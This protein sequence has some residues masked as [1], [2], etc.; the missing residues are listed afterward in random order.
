MTNYCSF[1]QEL[2][3]ALKTTKA[4]F[5]AAPM[6]KIITQAPE[7]IQHHTLVKTLEILLIVGSSIEQ[8]SEDQLRFKSFILSGSKLLMKWFYLLQS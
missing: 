5:M 3:K 1:Q 8:L 4:C 6:K 2:K 7:P